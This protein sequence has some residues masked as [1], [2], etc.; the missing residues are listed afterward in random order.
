MYYTPLYGNN[1]CNILVNKVITNFN[2]IDRLHETEL[3]IVDLNQFFVIKGKTTVSNPLNYSQIFSEYIDSM[4]DIT[5]TYSIIDLIEYDTKPNNNILYLCETFESNISPDL[6]D[7]SSNTQ[8]S[9]KIDD[10]NK[11]ILTNN[12]I[13]GNKIISNDPYTDYKLLNYEN[14]LPFLSDS[15]YGKN[16]ISDKIIKVYLNYISYN[17]FEK[18]LL[19]DVTFELFYEGNIKNLSWDNMVLNVKSKT[20]IVNLDWIHSFILDTFNFNPESIKKHLSLES[21][22]FEKE[23]ISNDKCWKINDKVSEI[24]L[25]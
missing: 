18:Q 19:K 1:L 23:I 22:N 17:L 16:L 10:K 6:Y 15:L 9:Y 13:L 25:L 5:R 11:I 24:I 7:L 2:D 21:Y 12:K 4:S 3:M 8:G 14:N 20:S